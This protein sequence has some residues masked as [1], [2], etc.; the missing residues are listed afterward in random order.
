LK[1]LSG[2]IIESQK[3]GKPMILR[4]LNTGFL[5]VLTLATISCGGS[6]SSSGGSGGGGGSTTSNPA[7]RAASL[8]PTSAPAGSSAV[9]LTVIGSGFIPGSVVNWNGS[10]LV[11]VYASSIQLTATIT[12]ADL[13]SSGTAAVTVY[14]P[15]P[16]GGTSS[17]LTFIITTVSPVSITTISLPSASPT[18]SYNYS[19]QASGGISPFTWSVVSGAL[20]SGISLSSS[21]VLSGTPASVASDTSYAFAVQAQDSSYSPRT[22]IQSFSILVHSGNLGSNNS[23]PAT[24]S[25]I[26][27]GVI[28]ASISPFGDVDVY[29]FQGTAG[30]KITAEIYAQRLPIGSFLDSFLELLDSNCNQLTYNDDINP[31]VLLDSRISNYTLPSTGTYYLRVSDMRGDGRP[32]FIYELHLS[33]A[34]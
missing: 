29:S 2:T 15:T 6:S 9:P 32:D 28:R 10:N 34:N 16:G 8:S 26:S 27:N 30:N 20:P 11:T 7:P 12:P 14:N 23:C 1:A 25:A 13:A 31:G 22:S 19:L 33:G 3:V 5:V 4:L 24:Q 18:K 17:S 21:G